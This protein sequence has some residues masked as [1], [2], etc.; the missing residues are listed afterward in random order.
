MKALFTSGLPESRDEWGGTLSLFLMG[1][2]SDLR[3]ACTLIFILHLIMLGINWNT[4]RIKGPFQWAWR[5][6]DGR[7]YGC[8]ERFRSWFQTRNAHSILAD[9]VAIL[10]TI[11]IACNTSVF[12]L[13]AQLQ[14]KWSTNGTL[15]DHNECKCVGQLL[16]EKRRSSLVLE[17]TVMISQRLKRATTDYLV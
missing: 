2:F 17:L 10:E 12:R 4:E 15:L 9:V 6:S 3:W 1:S 13:Q 7:D 8:T 14:F 11:I 16:C 5:S